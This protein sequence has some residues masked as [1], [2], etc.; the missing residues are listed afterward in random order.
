M[1]A[2][3][4]NVGGS[5]LFRNIKKRRDGEYDIFR[6]RRLFEGIFFQ[7]NRKENS[8]DGIRNNDRR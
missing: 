6:Y 8:E 5:K 4:N 7:K 2:L 1:E 3:T